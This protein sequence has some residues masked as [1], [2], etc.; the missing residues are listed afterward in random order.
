MIVY[1]YIDESCHLENDGI[2][3]MTLGFIGVNEVRKEEY[4]ATVQQLL[5]KHKS[6]T[7]LKWNKVSA[8]RLPL[9]KALI[10]FFFEANLTFRCVLVKNKH[11]LE[12]DQYKQGSHDNFYYNMVYTLLKPYR[13][14]A[15]YRVFLDIKDTRGREKLDKLKKHFDSLEWYEERFKSFQTISS[16]ESTFMQL[17]DFFIGAVAFKAR[18]LCEKNESSDVKKEIVKYL[19]QKSGY[20]LDEGTS[21]LEDKFCIDDFQPK[22][23]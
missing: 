19:E 8:S 1:K 15:S 7:E 5:L 12:H 13:D 23:R 21:P 10:D 14:E 4:E 22:R 3:I 18:G 11:R 16:H 2:D 20:D 17:A 6:P 9:Y